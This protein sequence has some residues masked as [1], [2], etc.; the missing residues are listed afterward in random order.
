MARNPYQLWR[1]LEKDDVKVLAVI[2]SLQGRYEYVPVELLE[3]RTRLPGPRIKRSLDKLNELK[4]IKRKLGSIIGYSLTFYGL[5]VLSLNNLIA[6]NVIAALGDRIGVGKEGSVYYALT[7]SGERVVV[8]FHREGRRTFRRIRLLRSYAADKPRKHWL[9]IAKLIGEREFKALV[10]LER[11][12]ARVPR[13]IAWNRNAV[14]Q[15]YIPGVELYRVR[16]LTVEE[17]EAV[18]EDIVETIRIA[19]ARVGIVHGD[20]SEYNVLVPENGGAY[21]IDWPQYAYRE[22]EGAD[23][24]LQRDLEYISRYFRKRFGI[25]VDWRKLL[26]RVRGNAP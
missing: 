20:L 3:R 24:L 10:E 6:R 12:G 8:K 18:L 7:P 13:A 25:Q 5:D 17:A 14:V 9:Q 21:I 1:Q 4:L 26:E 11:E 16:G 22:E 23:L 19:Y 15:E 2:E